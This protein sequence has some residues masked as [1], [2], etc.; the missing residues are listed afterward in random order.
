MFFKSGCRTG[1]LAQVYQDL[2]K[3]NRIEAYVN[4]QLFCEVLVHNISCDGFRFYTESM[5]FV[6]VAMFEL[7][8]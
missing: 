5:D 3:E 6:G 1:Y 7:S 8:L 2:E 4:N